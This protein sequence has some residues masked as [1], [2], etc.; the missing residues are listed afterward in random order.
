MDYIKYGWQPIK[1]T[2]NKV[3]NSNC[4]D[5]LFIN[6][7]TNTVMINNYPL[8]PSESL[9]V[10]GNIGEYTDDGVDVSFDGGAGTNILWVIRRMYKNSN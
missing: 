9:P 2:E 10:T 1:V 4:I 6:K 3:I 8:E 5:M 7:G